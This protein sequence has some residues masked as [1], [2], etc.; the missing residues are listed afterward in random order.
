M[1]QQKGAKRALKVSSR[2]RKLE[3]KEQQVNLK[4]LERK[5]LEKT[6]D[7]AHK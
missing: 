4:K 5:S 6:H 3:K 7:H 2:K 1:P